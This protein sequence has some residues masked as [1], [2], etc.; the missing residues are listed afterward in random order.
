[1]SIFQPRRLRIVEK[2]LKNY[3]GPVGGVEFK[4]GVSVGVV[5]YPTSQRIGACMEIV[6][7]DETDE[8]ALITPAAAALRN[9][10]LTTDSPDVIAFNEGTA[11]DP[12]RYESIVFHTQEELEAIANKGGLPA[13]LSLAQRWGRKGRTIPACIAAIMQEQDKAKAEKLRHDKL[14]AETPVEQAAEA[15]EAEQEEAKEAETVDAPET[16][17]EDLA[18]EEAK[19]EEAE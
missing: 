12:E 17:G 8:R 18:K 15:E 1:M 14:A 16:A 19:A 7:A 13:I 6:D 5:D 9:R 3:S 10:N 11:F 2:N 4:D